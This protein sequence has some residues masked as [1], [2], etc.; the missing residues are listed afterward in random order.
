MLARIV[1]STLVGIDAIAVDVE[2]D[3]AT[4]LPGYH[5][6]GLPAPPVKEGAVRIRSALEQVGHGLPNKK[7]TVN[8]APADV[9]KPSPALD[10]PIA[11]GVLVADGLYPPDALDRILVLGELG[12]D[13][14]LRPVRGALASAMLA[15]SME[16]RGILL[17]AASA[18]EAM[19][20]EGIDVYGATHL[21]EV[22]AALAGA[23]RLPEARPAVRRRPRPVPPLDMSDVRGQGL[24]RAAL[25]IAVAGGHNALLTGPPGIGTPGPMGG[26]STV[27]S[28][29]I[30]SSRAAVASPAPA[31]CARVA[32]P[33]G[34]TATRPRRLPGPRN[35]PD[36]GPLG[37]AGAA[38]PAKTVN[39]RAPA[40]AAAAS[41]ATTSR[42]GR[43]SEITASPLE[44]AC[45]RN[46]WFL[47]S[48]WKRA[49]CC[50]GRSP[51]CS[52]RRSRYARTRS[53]VSVRGNGTILA[54]KSVS[55]SSIR[56][57]SARSSLTR[58]SRCES[59]A[60][61]VEPSKIV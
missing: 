60:G 31:P 33:D 39:I 7:V 5:V 55:S 59:W 26:P 54:F 32:A 29:M 51:R 46:S 35:G 41:A 56:W 57:S 27:V 2:V 61:S 36:V 25:E 22:I 30:D 49:F 53:S 24:A 3:V 1:S 37:R 17:P 12:L 58:S 16:L 48:S 6:V 23:A 45:T 20:V 4:G 42:K 38:S 19:V 13:G 21:A 40:T 18:A 47:R 44:M 8:L 28:T 34:A 10:L 52:R 14:S 9:R 43:A 11:V 50:S 15:R